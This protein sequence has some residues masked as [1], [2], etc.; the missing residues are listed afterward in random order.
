MTPAGTAATAVDTDDT[1]ESSPFSL[2]ICHAADGDL[3]AGGGGEGC[4][5]EAGE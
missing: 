1:S 4:G 2:H 3:P 5:A